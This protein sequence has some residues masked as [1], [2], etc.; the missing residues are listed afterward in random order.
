MPIPNQVSSI[1]R[2]SDAAS[3]PP[4]IG[5]T[6][7]VAATPRKPD[8]ND[9]RQAPDEQA[10][11][12]SLLRMLPRARSVLEIGARDSY[13]TRLLSDSFERV[14][15]LDL[16]RP[17]PVASNVICVAGDVRSLQWGPNEF[18]AVLCSEVLEHIPKNDLERSCRELARVARR[19]VLVGVPFEQDLRVARTRC[20]RC[21][22]INP[23]Y[24]HVN[25][26]TRAGL[27][28]LFPELRAVAEE[29]I[30]STRERTTALSAKLADLAGHPWGTYDQD[31]P[32]LACGA[33]VG[34]PPPQSRIS[35][36]LT[37]LASRID[38]TARALFRP[39]PKWLHV[40]YEKTAG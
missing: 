27:D 21:G 6:A 22:A 35:R 34:P 40:L 37:A 12:A 36:A 28:S 33:A 39:R 8:V 14:V 32:C 4:R 16:E 31:E 15:S 23:P 13:I 38:S 11:I 29:R 19:F 2:T 7:R 25:R 9:F 20:A 24:G 26:F 5:S 1:F 10:R 30:G 3:G 18:E 17:K